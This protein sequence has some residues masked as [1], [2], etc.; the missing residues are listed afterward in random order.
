MPQSPP[1]FLPLLGG[2]GTHGRTL[3]DVFHFICLKQIMLIPDAYLRTQF[4]TESVHPPQCPVELVFILRRP[5]IVVDQTADLVFELFNGNLPAG[6]GKFGVTIP[7]DVHDLF[8]VNDGVGYRTGIFRGVF[9]R[10][11]SIGESSAQVSPG[12]QG[13]VSRRIQPRH[14]TL[15]ALVD[16]DARQTVPAA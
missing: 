5:Y 10:N 2:H 13:N 1:A 16:P 7:N 11:L 8:V 4:T 14:G 3:D 12:H 9:R 6:L 15:S